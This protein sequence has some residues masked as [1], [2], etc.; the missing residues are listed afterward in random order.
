MWHKY[1]KRIS[2]DD[3]Y[4]F[5]LRHKYK[6]ANAAQAIKRIQKIVDNDGG[7]LRLRALGITEAEELMEKAAASRS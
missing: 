5:L 3:L 7:D 1:P 6:K 4:D 2:E